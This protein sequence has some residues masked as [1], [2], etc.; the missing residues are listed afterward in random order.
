MRFGNRIFVP[1]RAVL[2]VL[3]TAALC[4]FWGCGRSNE[5]AVFPLDFLAVDPAP[6]IVA[7][8]LGNLEV[9]DGLGLR[10]LCGPETVLRFRTGT[11][12]PLRLLFRFESPL[13]GQA[14]AVAVNGREAGTFPADATALREAAFTTRAGEN[15]VTLRFAV[16][17]HGAVTFAPADPRRLAGLFRELTLSP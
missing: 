12:A 3:A 7:D 10:W 8:G 2:A 1:W 4:I 5:Q 11:A 9:A 17:N 13:P 6:G 16:W 14:V 15:V